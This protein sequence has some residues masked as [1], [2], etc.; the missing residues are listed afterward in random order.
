LR[1]KTRER[2]SKRALDA[3]LRNRVRDIQNIAADGV[4]WCFTMMILERL[5]RTAF[6]DCACTGTWQ[7]LA[8]TD[9]SGGTLPDRDSVAAA[10]VQTGSRASAR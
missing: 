3:G 4:R 9:G 1:E 10:I 8:Q 6:G 5:V 2:I 7:E